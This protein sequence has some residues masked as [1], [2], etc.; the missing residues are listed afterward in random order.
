MYLLASFASV[1]GD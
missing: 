1:S